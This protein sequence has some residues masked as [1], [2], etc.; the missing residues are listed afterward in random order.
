MLAFLTTSTEGLAKVQTE[1]T[2]KNK[3]VET[4]VICCPQKKN[5]RFRGRVSFND[6]ENEGYQGPVSV[7]THSQAAIAL[8]V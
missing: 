3:V 8:Q 7:E 4:D 1:C 5:V 6:D 2:N